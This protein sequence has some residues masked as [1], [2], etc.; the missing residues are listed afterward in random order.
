MQR[1]RFVADHHG[2]ARIVA[3]VEAGNIVDLIAV[4]LPAPYLEYV[5]PEYTFSVFF[6][7]GAELSCLLTIALKC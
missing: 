2:M 1:I 3:A 6:I 4:S 7:R 5:S